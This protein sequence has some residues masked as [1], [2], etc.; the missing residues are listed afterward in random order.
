[1]DSNTRVL[2]SAV[3]RVLKPLARILLRHGIS[4]GGFTDIAKRAYVDVAEHEFVLENRKQ[5]ISRIAVLTGVHRKEVARVR[6]L[7]PL[8]E[9]QLD[10]RYNRARRVISGWL[11][12]SEFLDH[13]GEPE[14]L[15]F[16]GK[17]GFNDLV[18]RYSGDVPSRAVA[19]ELM[20]VGAVKLNRHNKLCLSS[21]SKIPI[22]RATDTLQMLGTDTRDLIETIDHN[23]SHPTQE[24]S[25]QRN[26]IYDN[27]P[28]EAIPE[29]RRLATRLGQA[30][31]EQLNDWLAERDRD[32]NSNIDGSG[33]VRL[34]MGAYL[35]ED[36]IESGEENS[37]ASA[38]K[39]VK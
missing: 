17:R 10:E 34:G 33:R 11:C 13:K 26:V 35:I 15:A 6:N 12:D 39:A 22:A 29:F 18:K 38:K 32:S 28:V 24:S 1:M 16:E 37:V 19:D 25:F 3:F 36:I 14:T 20:R 2:A 27:V 7:P 21:R 23:L 5:T 9:C 8:E 30:T 4:F 31:L